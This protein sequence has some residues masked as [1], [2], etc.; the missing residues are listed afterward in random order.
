[1]PLPFRY[2]LILA[3]ARRAD[4]A[5]SATAAGSGVRR[6]NPLRDS[7]EEL[8]DDD[9]EQQENTMDWVQAALKVRTGYRLPSGLQCADGRTGCKRPSR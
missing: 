9:D 8:D 4:A 2:G 1:M 5:R 3:S 6:L 7:D